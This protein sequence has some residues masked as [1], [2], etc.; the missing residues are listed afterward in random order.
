VQGGPRGAKSCTVISRHKRDFDPN[1]TRRKYPGDAGLPEVGAAPG[2]DPRSRE[3]RRV[4]STARDL[5]SLSL[6]VGD[7]PEGCA[8]VSPHEQLCY[9][10]SSNQ[11]RGHEILAE[12]ADDDGRLR[13]ACE[14]PLDGSPR[15][16]ETCTVT[17]AH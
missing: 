8:T 15:A 2:G 5:L 12:I 7:A 4:L 16:A 10:Q 14:L 6:L 9:W 1:Q 11:A 17:R 13:M 3:A